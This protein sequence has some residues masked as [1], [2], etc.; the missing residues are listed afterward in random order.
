MCITQPPKLIRTQIQ[1]WFTL[2][3]HNVSVNLSFF[4]D[5]GEK[6]DEIFRKRTKNVYFVEEWN[7]ESE[8][9]PR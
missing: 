5:L 2:A 8:A 3:L 6:M 7:D 1:R 9:L 4:F